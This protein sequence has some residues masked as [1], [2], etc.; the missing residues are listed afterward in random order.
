MRSVSKC[1]WTV[2]SCDTL[3]TESRLRPLAR[4]R[5]RTLPGARSRRRFELMTAQMTV[6]IALSLKSLD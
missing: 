6:R 5:T 3:T 4:A 1:L 2:I